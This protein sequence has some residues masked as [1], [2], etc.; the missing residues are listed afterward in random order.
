[1]AEGPHEPRASSRLEPE[2]DQRQ[3]IDV[4]LEL[5]LRWGG[6]EQ[7]PTLVYERS[8]EKGRVTCATMHHR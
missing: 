1:M 3:R 8:Q 4:V 7:R 2:G 6:G 5:K